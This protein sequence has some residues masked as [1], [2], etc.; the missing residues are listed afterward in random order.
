MSKPATLL[1]LCLMFAA[2]AAHADH[3]ADTYVIPIAGHTTGPN[4]TVWM[5]DIVIRNFSIEPIT[6]EM[7]FIEAGEMTFDNVFPLVTDTL[8]G[9]VTVRGNETVFLRD[10]LKGYDQPNVSGAII[11][12]AERPF[13]VTSRTYNNRFALGQTVPATGDFLTQTL[14]NP[15][16]SAYAYIPGIMQTPTTRTNVGFVAGAGPGGPMVVQFA[17]RQSAG[18]IAGTRNFTI[19]AGSFEQLQ[20]PVSS[21]TDAVIDVGTVEVRIVSGDGS[22]VPYASVVDGPTGEATFIMG[23]LPE[24]DT[25]GALAFRT[26]LFRSLFGSRDR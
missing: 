15:D 5:T 9:S 11:L 4:N 10:V 26:N 6:V 2:T 13:A 25:S 20:F 22:V 18:G 3:Y 14:G 19:P 23:Q 8:D 17:V 24:N 12:G 16:N 7:L 1:L 21:V